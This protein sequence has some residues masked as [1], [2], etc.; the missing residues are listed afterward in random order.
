[1]KAAVLERPVPI[2]VF[3]ADRVRA[4]I[5]LRVASTEKGVAKAEIAADLAP[6]ASHRLPAGHW[7]ALIEREIAALAD[8][9]LAATKGGRIEASEAGVARAGIFLGLK[10]NLPRSW[11]EVRDVRLIAKMMGLEREAPKR[12]KA[13]ATPD[14][15]RAAIVQRAYK[16]K[17][18]GVPTPSRLRSALAAMALER[19]FGNQM[20]TG[21]AGKLGLSAKAGRLLAAQLSQRPRDFGTDRPPRRRARRR[22]RGCRAAR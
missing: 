2:A 10:G 17:I 11:P 8:A 20:Q 3:D 19:A 12:L 18:K 15:L 6:L 1:M 22:A 21:L 16:L 13:L 9:G 4:I 5:L 14:G 7:R